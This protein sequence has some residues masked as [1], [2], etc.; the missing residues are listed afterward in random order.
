[1]LVAVIMLVIVRMIVTMRM[2]MM[3]VSTAAVIVVMMI[4]IVTMMMIVIVL[5]MTMVVMAVMRMA[6]I[7]VM[8]SDMLR[9]GAA[10]RIE[11]RLD[12]AGFRAE[13]AHHVGN[14]MVAADAQFCARD[15]RRQMSVAEVPGN[16][17]EMFLVARADL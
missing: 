3:I 7:V 9:I 12:L 15:L 10:F 6:V 14:H 11:R 16:A 2:I 1:M 17:H 4:M 13:A 5:V 8:R